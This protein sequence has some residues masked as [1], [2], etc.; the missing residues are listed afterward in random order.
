MTNPFGETLPDL[1][2]ER[3]RFN[4][5]FDDLGR[6][7]EVERADIAHFF[8]KARPDVDAELR[9]VRVRRHPTDRRRAPPTR[10]GVSPRARRSRSSSPRQGSAA[11]CPCG[12]GTVRARSRRSPLPPRRSRRQPHLQR[13]SRVPDRPGAVTRSW[14]TAQRR[15]R[16]G[17]CRRRAQSD[18]CQG[19]RKPDTARTPRPRPS[20]RRAPARFGLGRAG[21]W[22][23]WRWSG[24]FA[25]WAQS[26]QA[27]ADG[28]R[29]R[30]GMPR[31]ARMVQPHTPGPASLPRCLIVDRRHSGIR[32]RRQWGERSA[33]P[34]T[35]ARG[36]PRRQVGS[37][38]GTTR[39]TEGRG[40]QLRVE[41]G[42][43]PL[44]PHGTSG[45]P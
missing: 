44:P 38:A 9:R 3:H 15:R 10:R 35:R 24:S 32:T 25:G 18:G 16:A 30:A 14:D 37:A 13:S 17:S 22:S 12:R 5:V 8:E 42:D 41:N 39:E 21:G 20:G 43:V 29:C 45:L 2:E 34:R 36:L 40:G 26:L 33:E 11:P 4:D 23:W 7:D 6:Q 19:D 1:N 31:R 28:P 27:P